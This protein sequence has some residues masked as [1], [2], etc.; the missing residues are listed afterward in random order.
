MAVPAESATVLRPTREVCDVQALLAASRAG[1]PIWSV[2]LP[3]VMVNV[4]SARC[5]PLAHSRDDARDALDSL[6]VLMLGD[7]LTR[8]QYLSLAYFIESGNWSSPA[9]ER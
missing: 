3:G 7:S 4:S 5:D 9:G 2:G 6:H 1:V 8:Y